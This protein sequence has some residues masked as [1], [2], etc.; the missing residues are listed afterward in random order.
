MLNMHKVEKTRQI[1]NILQN[2]EG[3]IRTYVLLCLTKI[4]GS[5]IM[6]L[7]DYGTTGLREFRFFLC[8]IFVYEPILIKI[9]M[10]I[11]T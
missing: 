8:S 11:K 9:S 6:G 1:E 2:F 3:L 7:R 4:R 10:I 5:G